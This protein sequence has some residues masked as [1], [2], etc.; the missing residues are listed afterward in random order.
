MVEA[1]TGEVDQ[2]GQEDRADDV[3]IRPRPFRRG[4]DLDAVGPSLEELLECERA[5]V[6]RR[7]RVEAV[8]Q[9]VDVARV[10]DGMR[11]I[12]LTRSSSSRCR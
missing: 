12:R 7:I 10:A 1:L 11:V 9:R 2:R 8:G 6:R 4:Q 3:G 5:R